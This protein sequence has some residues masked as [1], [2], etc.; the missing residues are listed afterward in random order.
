[1]RIDIER[2]GKGGYI[3]RKSIDDFPNIGDNDIIVDCPDIKSVINQLFI[4]L[5]S[6]YVTVNIDYQTQAA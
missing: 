3:V 2:N 5:E 6:R 1:M 4:F